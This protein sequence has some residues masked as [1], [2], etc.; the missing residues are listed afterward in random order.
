MKVVSEEK[1]GKYSFKCVPES[2]CNRPSHLSWYP[3]VPR[4][5][6]DSNVSS[7]M[8]PAHHKGSLTTANSLAE[9]CKSPSALLCSKKAWGSRMG[10]WE[11]R[12]WHWQQKQTH[13][14]IAKD[15][16]I[17]LNDVCFLILTIETRTTNGWF[18]WWYLVRASKSRFNPLNARE[19]NVWDALQHTG[20]LRWPYFRWNINEE[21]T[22][23]S[24]ETRWSSLPLYGRSGLEPERTSLPAHFLFSSSFSSSTPS[25]S[26][27]HS[28]REIEHQA[29][30]H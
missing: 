24:H 23:W 25:S 13:S 27:N 15:L 21:V 9:L 17:C 30:S 10:C 6:I 1:C 18:I 2:L 3:P 20:K 14:H 4:I 16:A 19:H 22:G 5:S 26:S 11:K 7:A 28:T 29:W 8:L 12:N